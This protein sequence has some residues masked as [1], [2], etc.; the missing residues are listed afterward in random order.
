VTDPVVLPHSNKINTNYVGEL[1]FYCMEILNA[2]EKP[3][4]E[5]AGSSGASHNP[6][7]TI[8][9]MVS[10]YATTGIFFHCNK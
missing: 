9:C 7:F 3:I 8:K 10:S 1:A 4:Y 6:T 2:P 5:E